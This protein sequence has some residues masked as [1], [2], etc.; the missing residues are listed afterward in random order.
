M[1]TLHL[2]ILLYADTLS[3]SFFLLEI[4][5]LQSTIYT[6]VSVLFATRIKSGLRF[7][8]IRLNFDPIDLSMSM[9][10]EVMR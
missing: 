8:S 2:A 5:N 6:F 1:F 10:D 7:G 4:S 9:D 3:L